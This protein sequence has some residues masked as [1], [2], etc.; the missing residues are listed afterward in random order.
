[1]P[2]SRSSILI[3]LDL[4]RQTPR[5][6]DYQGFRWQTSYATFSLRRS[7]VEQVLPYIGDQES[8]HRHRS[9]QDELRAFLVRH[10]ISF[11]ERY[12]WD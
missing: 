7:N 12:F 3:P 6:L 2:Q 10:E 4:Q 8:H 5:T 9:F 11:D 1:M